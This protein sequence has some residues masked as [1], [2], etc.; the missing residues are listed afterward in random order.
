MKNTERNKLRK[1]CEEHEWTATE[2]APGEWTFETWSDL[3][4]DFIVS[5]TGVTLSGIAH[6]LHGYWMNFD[7]EEHA[8]ACYNDPTAP[9]NLRA[10]LKDAEEMEAR[11]EKLFLAL[12]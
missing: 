9:H 8:A 4:E 5:A 10:L 2:D 7:P 6:D 12:V 3:G 11:I 1:I